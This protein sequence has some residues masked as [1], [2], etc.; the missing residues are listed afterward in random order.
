M[1]RFTS[2]AED[3]VIRSCQITK[4][5]ALGSTVPACLLQEALVILVFK[6]MSQFG[7]FCEKYSAKVPFCSGSL[8]WVNGCLDNRPQVGE[9]DECTTSV[10]CRVQQRTRHDAWMKDWFLAHNS[11]SSLLSTWATAHMSSV[12]CDL[13]SDC[14]CEKCGVRQVHLSELSGSEYRYCAH[15]SAV[16][17]LL[18]AR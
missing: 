15:P 11:D 12:L 18:A 17:L 8:Q 10:Q 14:I 5:S 6:Q 9:V 13:W 2:F 16:P 4:F 3:F 7:S 1:S